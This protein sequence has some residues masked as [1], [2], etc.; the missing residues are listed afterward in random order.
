MS[1]D[2]STL[3]SGNGSDLKL[4]SMA[5]SSGSFQGGAANLQ[6]AQ[7]FGIVSKSQLSSCTVSKVQQFW[8]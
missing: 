7:L 8:T 6:C 1:K 4:Q 5:A 2:T 3:T